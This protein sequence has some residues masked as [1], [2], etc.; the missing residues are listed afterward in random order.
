LHS[1]FGRTLLAFPCLS[2][3]N[4]SSTLSAL[5]LGVQNIFAIILF[6]IIKL[7][8]KKS[9]NISSPSPVLMSLS[10][11][12]YLKAF[13]FLLNQ[14]NILFPVVSAEHFCP[15]KSFYFLLV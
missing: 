9:L 6:D 14:V 5:S 2:L 12:L 11:E 3:L 7:K 15:S 13:F 4:T 1:A 8:K 10:S